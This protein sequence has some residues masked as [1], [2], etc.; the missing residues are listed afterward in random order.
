MFSL[1]SFYF[2]CEASHYTSI[3][4]WF[5]FP[6]LIFAISLLL[7]YFF[8]FHFLFF[9]FWFFYYYFTIFRSF[10]LL[11]FSSFYLTN[12]YLWDMG[13]RTAA[14]PSLSLQ[15]SVLMLFGKWVTIFDFIYP[16]FSFFNG[17]FFFISI[18]SFFF[19]NYSSIRISPYFRIC[20]MV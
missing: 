3:L 15:T 10:S 17:L 5:F 14:Y 13:W 7:F 20:N 18:S 6:Y 12:F 4:I 16:L 19:Y 8:L 2:M 9:V 1:F 11:D